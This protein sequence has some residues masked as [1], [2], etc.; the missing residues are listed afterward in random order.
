MKPS[1]VLKDCLLFPKKEAVVRLNKLDMKST[2]IYFFILMIVM[3]L[4]V[5]IRLLFEG[6]QGNNSLYITQVL[7]LSPL[8]MFFYGL[9]GITFL[10]GC[11]LVLSRLL[12]RKLKFQLLWKMNIFALTKPVIAGVLAQF[13][14][15]SSPVVTLIVFIIL[16]VSIVRMVCVYPKSR[17]RSG[18]FLNSK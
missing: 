18:T 12:Q 9:A 7:I 10:E 4:P 14:I 1:A 2:I 15:G 5:E 11:S 16:A 6:N 8:F 3:L 13:I 17:E